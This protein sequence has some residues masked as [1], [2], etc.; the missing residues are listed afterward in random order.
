MTIAF[1]VALS[2]TQQLVQPA[3]RRALDALD[4]QTRA[5]A[6]YHL[7]WTGADGRPE[8]GGGGKSL[9]PALALLSAQA[10]GADAD[11]AVPGAVAVELVHNFSL[12][13]DDLMDGDLS[14]RHR[15]TVWALWGP[16]SAIL[17]G[18][19]MLTLAHQVLLE[20]P[21]DTGPA[22]SRLL[23]GSTQ[24]LIRGQ[25]EDVHFEGRA[26]VTLDQCL[27]MAAGKTGALIAASCAIGAVLAGAPDRLVRALSDFGM[28]LGLAF[29]LVDDVLGIWGDPD[30]TGKPVLSDLRSRKNSLPVSYALSR[31]D[32]VSA[33]LRAW[34]ADGDC[35]N[36]ARL[37]LIAA[38]V[39]VGGGRAWAEQ[40][41]ERRVRDGV[42]LLTTA[43]I[44]I[45]VRDELSAIG[46]FIV[47][48]Q[49]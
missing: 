33:E 27:E 7:G 28:Q 11:V 20:I 15:P 9:R 40:E 42:E 45:E 30:V 35:E 37:S 31:G 4:P 8:S 43:G 12:L 17:V 5:R 18:D 16:P 24:R 21:G 2:E 39:E 23:A 36:E 25:V 1:P 3:L 34:L 48:R 26:D 44:P 46:E 19:A 32:H 49:H 41:A 38:L 14:R 10:A 6:S 22:A 13:H 29:Q 47:A